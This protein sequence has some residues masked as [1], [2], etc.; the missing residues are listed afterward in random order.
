MLNMEEDKLKQAQLAIEDIDIPD[1]RLDE[2]VSTGISKGKRKQYHNRLLIRT[3]ASAA[4]LI[5]AF[6]ALLRTSETFASYITSIPGM[7]RIVEL[8][9]FDKGLTAAIENDFAQKI[10]MSDEHDGLKITLDSV[11]VDEQ[12]M[13]LFYKMES[14][15]G[16]KDISIEN[17]QLTDDQG[18]TLEFS[19]SI[20]LGPI[21]MQKEE[22]VYQLT[23]TFHDKVPPE[24]MKLS[25]HL[26]KGIGEN[27]ELTK[28]TDTWVLPY[29]ID[30]D[31]FKDKKELI[32]VNQTVTIEDQ[33]ITI[34]KVSIYPTRIG[35]TVHFDEKNSKQIF[36][37][38]DMRLVDET[39]EEWAA[40]ADGTTA[41]L[42]SDDRHEL[43]LQSNFFQ[44][45][46]ELYLQFNSLRAL[47]KDQ[48]DVVVDPEKMEILQAPSDGRLLEVS[49]EGN[50]LKFTF[51][52]DQK[53]EHITP[54]YQAT[55][56]EGK[57]IDGGHSSSWRSDVGLREIFIPYFGMG[58]APGPITL[59]VSDYPSWIKGEANIKLK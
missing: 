9:R 44:K 52:K 32:G 46:K 36:R 47:D 26:A 14:S 39:G 15:A 13:V 28:L 55:D 34:E 29:S 20:W 56:S 54:F 17:V 21:D 3:L 24:N 33:K 7:E 57:I 25:F 16:H 40:I 10:G 27:G 6:T 37:F 41:S 53:M 5:F 42:F 8:V 48:V 59:K 31:A 51:Q 43:Y 18:K 49:R 22:N 1:I 11:I 35:V 12:M 58:A 23:Y 45:P 2:A 19:S 30:R 38:E 50:D 4:I